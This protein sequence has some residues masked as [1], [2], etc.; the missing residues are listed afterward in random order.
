M[1]KFIYANGFVDI[2]EKIALPQGQ[3]LLV[4][5]EVYGSLIAKPSSITTITR[6]KDY[7]NKFSSL[8]E[9]AISEYR[10]NRQRFSNRLEGFLVNQLICGVRHAQGYF[11]GRQHSVDNVWACKSPVSKDNHIGLEI[12]LLSKL[13]QNQF[14]RLLKAHPIKR[15][16]SLAQDG[17][18]ESSDIAECDCGADEDDNCDDS[19]ARYTEGDYAIEMRLLLK[20]SE[21]NNVMSLLKD[22]LHNSEAYTNQTCG[23]HVHLDM[24]YRDVGK[25]Y[26]RLFL[27]LSGLMAKVSKNRLNNRY[28]K[29]NTRSDFDSQ[30]SIGDRYFMINTQS[31]DEHSTIEI[32]LHEGTTDTN[33]IK[34]WV[35][36]LITTI[37]KE[38]TTEQTQIA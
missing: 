24:R 31:Y 9:L 27:N 8:E 11:L 26:N 28:C 1:Q 15:Y 22:F 20:E 37:E 34:D 18:I 14:L 6:S 19:C 30:N 21:L 25:V 12:E 33:K 32:R 29:M 2:I 10:I 7:F 3:F 5:H 36:F 23:L 4:N 38:I 35:N 17:S 16:V 13:T